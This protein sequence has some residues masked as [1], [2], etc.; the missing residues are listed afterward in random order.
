MKTERAALLSG[1]PGIGMRTSCCYSFILLYFFNYFTILFYNI[2]SYIIFYILHYIK[3]YVIFILYC[4]LY[5]ILSGKTSSASIVARACGFEP[6]EFNASDQRN[7]KHIEVCGP[8][9]RGD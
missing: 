4:I 1:P 5:H 7:K 6:V 8:R 3:F 9:G 2:I